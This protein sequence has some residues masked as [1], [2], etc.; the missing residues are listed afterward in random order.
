[1]YTWGVGMYACVFVCGYVEVRGCQMSS[2][3]NE[4]GF[5]AE[6]GLPI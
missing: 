2:L 3:F 6:Q 1:M 4:A 5:L